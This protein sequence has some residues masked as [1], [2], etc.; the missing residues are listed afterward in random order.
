ML[1]SY[2][3]SDVFSSDL[4]ARRDGQADERRPDL[5]RPRLSARRR[6]S[7]GCGD[8]QRRQGGGVALS[9][10][11]RQRRLHVGRQ[12]PQLRP[13]A[14]LSRSEEHTSELQSLMR[15]SY[16]VFCLKNKTLK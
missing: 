15:T 1:I 16:A 7:G 8:R 12:R 11:A 9:D 5:P 6:G 13:P 2:W 10:A 3:S 4:P 14:L